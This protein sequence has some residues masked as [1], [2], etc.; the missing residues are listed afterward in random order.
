MLSANGGHFVQVSMY[1]IKMKYGGGTSTDTLWF[2]LAYKW[3]VRLKLS[4]SGYFQTCMKTPN[5]NS[6][7]I[8]MEISAVRKNLL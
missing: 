1:N 7:L 4:Y 6:F 8:N 5:K 2:Q 3:D